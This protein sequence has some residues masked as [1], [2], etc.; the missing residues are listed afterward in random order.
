MAKIRSFT[1]ASHSIR[2]HKSEVDATYQLLTDDSGSTLFQ[3]S[4]Y[5]SDE[6]KSEPKVSQTIQLDE[7]FARELIAALEAAFGIAAR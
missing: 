3:L 6:R 7:K 5:G 2:P 1:K 4:T